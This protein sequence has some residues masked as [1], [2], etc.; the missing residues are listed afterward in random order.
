VWDKI[1]NDVE[2]YYAMCSWMDFFMNFG[3]IY[4]LKIIEQ[5]NRMDK[6]YVGLS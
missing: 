1:F 6:F 3:N 5:K 2:D 4:F